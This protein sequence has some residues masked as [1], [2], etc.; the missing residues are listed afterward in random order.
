M[1]RLEI[2]RENA[3][4]T[5]HGKVRIV[6]PKSWQT[7]DMDCGLSQ[8]KA[9]GIKMILEN[10]PL[11][12]G[13][14]ELIV[15]TRSMYSET[16]GTG[17]SVS[18][19]SY[20]TMPPYVNEKDIEY[21]GFNH[22]NI[23]K[24][25]Y[26]PD[27]DI[28]INLGINGIIKK[29][30]NAMKCYKLE[31]QLDFGHSV[32]IVYKALQKLIIK[33]SEYAKELAGKESNQRRKKELLEISDTCKNISNKPASNLKESCQLFWFLYLAVIIENFQFINYG[34][35][36]QIF[37]KYLTNETDLEI[38]EVVGSLLIKMYDQLD[39]FLVDKDLM[40]KYSAQH[41]ITIG[42][43]KRD[44]TDGSN[45]VTKA[46]LN[47]LKTTRLP[48]PLISVRVNSI[49]P[50]WLLN[51]S[52]GLS[53]SGLNCMA[54][55]ND[56]KVIDSLNTVGIDIE[57]ARDYGFGLCQDILIPGRGD[58][59]CS[60]GI[61]LTYILLDFI[62]KHKDESLTYKEFYNLYL[63]RLKEDIKNNINGYNDWEY[64][65][66]EYNKGNKDIYFKYIKEGKIDVDAPSLG[67]STAQAAASDTK[68]LKEI[69]V[70][71]LMSALPFSSSLYYGCVET[72]IDIS[73][74][75]SIRKDK[76]IMIL[77]PVVAFN[78]L[79]AL[80]K[81][82]FEDKIYTLNEVHNALKHNF[83]GFEEM[84]QI[85]WNSP[86]WANDDDYVDDDVVELI[87]FVSDEINK[88]STPSGGRHLSGIH[89]P[90]PVF[91]GR[92]ISA[93]PEG[94]FAGTPIPITI[95]PENGTLH[96]GP[97][98]AMKSASKFDYHRIQWNN[99][100]MLQYHSSTFA[101]EDGVLQFTQMT[102]RY[103]NLGGLQHQPNVVNIEK[104]KD[105]QINPE[106]H[107]NLII[108]MWGVSAHFVDLP[109]DVQ[110]EFI[111]RYDD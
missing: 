15:G 94:R 85:L 69:Y 42:G 21:F 33:Y 90:H 31:D 26:A 77:S 19:F 23:T 8:R 111:A 34:R 70:Q 64:A 82:V 92:N 102:Q 5:E 95:S 60:G 104:L 48:E 63:Q 55:Y 80:K 38:E 58:H 3:I 62:D 68:E 17:T 52:C 59:Y 43:I 14:E 105:A 25:H 91:A 86:K 7:K 29:T 98:A 6:M 97:L 27:Y 67:L 78:S 100:L 56:D 51:L 74:G 12:I 101:S 49:S 41:N 28:V 50:D 65:L 46:I 88:Y 40:G 18:C 22:E 57:D 84:R 72:G 30:E 108:R 103:F 9:H 2:L 99:C 93:T 61:N 109:K 35:I 96:N 71:T 45:R 75:G 10:M 107:K 83:E 44:G 11:Y 37:N 53:V 81:V 73:R 66:N 16:D 32:L 79:I 110:D 76:G 87:H 13:E 39:L 47:A 106:E 89:Q 4:K 1:Q 36:D 24:A 54:Y 20:V